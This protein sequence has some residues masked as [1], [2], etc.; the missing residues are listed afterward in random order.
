MHE[1][2]QPAM[3]LDHLEAGPQVQV[4]GVAEHD[5]GADALELLRA[6]SP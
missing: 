4:K 5:F 1:A 2:V 3:R 6:S